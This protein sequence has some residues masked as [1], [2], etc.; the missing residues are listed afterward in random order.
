[1]Q[2]HLETLQQF[3]QALYKSLPY[4]RDSLLELLDALS[5]MKRWTNLLMRST[6]KCPMHKYPF[7]LSSP[8]GRG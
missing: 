6:R 2:T 5:S 3:R 4:R 7:R 8:L 1:M